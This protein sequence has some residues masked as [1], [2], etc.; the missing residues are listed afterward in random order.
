[1]ESELRAADVDRMVARVLVDNEAGT[2]FY[3]REGYDLDG[4][5]SVE[6]GDETFDEREYRKQI[7]RLTGISE[8]TYKTEDGETVY[9]AFDESDRG[10]RAPFTSRTPT[11][12]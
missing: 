10:S 4:E 7:G 11:T 6:I 5:R 2:A 1:V 8:G 3:D 9:V 12:I